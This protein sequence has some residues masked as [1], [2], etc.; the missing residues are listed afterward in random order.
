MFPACTIGDPKVSSFQV[1]GTTSLDYQTTVLPLSSALRDTFTSDTQTVST[2]LTS[3]IMTSIVS[4]LVQ[5][6]MAMSYYT[7]SR[8]IDKKAFLP[9]PSLRERPSQ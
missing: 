5:V 6:M 1:R 4:V 7:T 2:A 3:E 9:N 8:L